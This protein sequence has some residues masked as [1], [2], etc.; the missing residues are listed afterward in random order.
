M[1]NCPKKDELLKL[2]VPTFQ[3][4]KKSLWQVMDVLKAYQMVPFPSRD[5]KEQ[6]T[7][8]INECAIVDGKIDH[9]NYGEM[10]AIEERL[11]SL[12][13][14]DDPIKRQLK[15]L[16]FERV[17]KLEGQQ[18]KPFAGTLDE[19]I[20]KAQGLINQTNESAERQSITANLLELLREFDLI[21]MSP[22]AQRM[23]LDLVANM[24][25]GYEVI[26]AQTKA[27]LRDVA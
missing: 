25:D 2:A 4:E 19:L 22:L 18:K 11:L 6:L 10:A 24:H 17:R 15:P 8:L 3:S 26:P 1:P 7:R 20:S 13:R 12:D 5:L 14:Q 16:Y 9:L 23:L 21:R 27:L